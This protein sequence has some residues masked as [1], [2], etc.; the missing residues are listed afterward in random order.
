MSTQKY[1]A[2]LLFILTSLVLLSTPVAAEEKSKQQEVVD[3]AVVVLDRFSID[4]NMGYF[5]E[6][7]KKAKAVFIVPRMLKGGFVI[8]GSGGSGVLLANDE[9]T[10]AWSYPVFYTMGSVSLG[11][12]AGAEASQIVLLVMTKKGMDSMLG[13]SFKLGADATIAAGPFG[14]GAKVAT[15]DILAYALSKGVYG[16]L[17]IEGATITSRDKWNTSYYGKPVTPVDVIVRK[18]VSNKEAEPLREEVEKLTR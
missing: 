8:G 10:G 17:S 13:T 6:M 18:T 7:V 4:S 3:S 5:R 14:G 15:T 1:V 12:Q 16:G 9:E 11:L 2:R